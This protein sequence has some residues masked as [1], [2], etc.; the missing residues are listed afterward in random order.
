MSN[1]AKPTGT[2][3]WMTMTRL[4]NVSSLV[5]ACVGPG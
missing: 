3:W 1:V 2:S 4:L 5:E